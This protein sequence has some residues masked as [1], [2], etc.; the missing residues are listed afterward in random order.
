MAIAKG[1][2][3]GVD[4]IQYCELVDPMALDALVGTITRPAALCTAV[5][6]GRTRLIDNVLLSPTGDDAQFISHLEG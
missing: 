1:E 5:V 3:A 4:E 2:L 6:I